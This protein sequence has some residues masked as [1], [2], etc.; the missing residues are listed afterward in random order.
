MPWYDMPLER[1]RE[2]RTE[3]SEPAGL[4]A[5]W[6]GRLELARAQAQPA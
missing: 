2:Y 6:A 5:W 1:L 3:T 4:D